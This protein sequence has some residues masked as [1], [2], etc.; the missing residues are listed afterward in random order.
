MHAPKFAAEALAPYMAG[1]DVTGE[2]IF[3]VS[4][5]PGKHSDLPNKELS[6]V[7]VEWS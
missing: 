4:Y 7:G 3:P 5:P 6:V 2:D 1:C